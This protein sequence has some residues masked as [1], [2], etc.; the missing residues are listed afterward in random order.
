MLAPAIGRPVVP[1]VPA[2][3]RSVAA[4]ALERLGDAAADVGTD[5]LRSYT[6]L[7]VFLYPSVTGTAAEKALIFSTLDRLPMKDV[8]AIPAIRVFPSLRLFSHGQGTTLGVTFGSGDMAVSRTDGF[9]MA[10]SDDLTRYIVMHES[11]HA[12]DFQ[13]GILHAF[14]LR[15]SSQGPWGHGP[16]PTEYAESARAEDFAEGHAFYHLRPEELGRVQNDV[17]ARTLDLKDFNAAKWQSMH[18]SEQPNLLEQVVAQKPFR[19][20]GRLVGQLTS[21][22]LGAAL[23]TGLGFMSMISS[24]ELMSMGVSDVI[25]GVKAQD[26][27]GAVRGGLSLA[28]GVSLAVGA[29]SPVL[30]PVALALLGA[31][32]GIDVAEKKASQ[33]GSRTAAAVG[34]A[35][36]GMVGGVAGPLGGTLAGY[37]VGGPVGGV[38]GLVAGSLV[39]FRGGAALGARAG[40]ALSR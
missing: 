6:A 7:P 12:H 28:A 31:R 4:P 15:H 18:D 35:V 26:T 3:P 13:G 2:R 34:G 29:G 24:F 10:N 14:L 36:G 23:H 33:G 16:F 17:G 37:A 8:G 20:T 40:L 30:G 39:G 9:G 32:R 21:N 19:E 38:I 5:A 27:L 25:D 11:G 1:F 22:Q